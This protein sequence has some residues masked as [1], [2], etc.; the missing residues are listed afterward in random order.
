MERCTLAVDGGAEVN[1]RRD[2]YS[3][4]MCPKY[5]RSNVRENVH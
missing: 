1:V 5:G 2:R 3:C 4:H